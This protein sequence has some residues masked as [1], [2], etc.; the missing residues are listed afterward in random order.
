MIPWLIIGGGIHGVHI[1]ARLIAEG[2]LSPEDLLIV[3]P[4]PRLLEAWR[5][6]TARTGMTYLRSPAVHHIDLD[7][8]S[9]LR[10][11]GRQRR[12]RRPGNFTPPYDR[13][14]L[15]FFN[16]HCDEVVRKYGLSDRHRQA[17]ATLVQ[18]GEKGVHVETS[19]GER[20]EA[21]RV[22]LALGS[23][24]AP[25]WPKWAQRPSRRIHHVFQIRFDSWD[26][27]KKQIIVVGG[28]ITAAQLALRASAAGAQVRIVSRH[29][30][31][32]HQFDSDPGWLGPK[33]MRAFQKLDSW[34]KRRDAIRAARHRGSMPPDV[35]AILQDSIARGRI[36]SHLSSISRVNE[37][38]HGVTV[39][40]EHGA[41]LRADELLLAT[42][43]DSARP[44]G[45]MVDELIRTAQLPCAPCGYPIVDRHLRWHRRIHVSG[46][47][48]ELMLGPIA[49]NIAGARRAGECIL[50]TLSQTRRSEDQDPLSKAS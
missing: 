19:T 32:K 29:S 28:G 16:A 31:R 44:G 30:F 50:A 25:H 38:E 8:M 4:E 17:S 35:H 21:G 36:R 43:W 10:F 47:L 15:A 42:G 3:D 40:L 23:G 7:P 27:E 2:D 14:S 24:G 6:M 5:R 18:P 46:P 13:P 37:D 20:L 48:A 39:E 49:R 34:E 33:N 22:L 45:A 11:G 12:F 1:A 26:V 9:L 41:S